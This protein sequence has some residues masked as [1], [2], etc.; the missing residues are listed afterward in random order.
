VI[1][2]G[3][4]DAV[5]EHVGAIARQIV[6][7]AEGGARRLRDRPQALQPVVGGREHARLGAG[8][9]AA[10][11]PTTRT[12]SLLVSAT[13]RLPPASTLVPSGLRSWAAVAGPPSP[14]SPAVPLP[15]TAVITTSQ[16]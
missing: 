15:A 7:V 8:L 5:A 14:L 1:V 2:V 10:P 12:R 6:A 16:G 3:K 13:N 9:G 11:W 4:R